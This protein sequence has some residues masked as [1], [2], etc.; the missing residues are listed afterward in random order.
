MLR[1]LTCC[2]I[3]LPFEQCKI[4]DSQ[5]VTFHA[6]AHVTYAVC[7]AAILSDTSS[8][9]DPWRYTRLH[10]L[11]PLPKY[12]VVSPVRPMGVVLGRH[13]EH[14]RY[15]SSAMCLEHCTR[16]GW[17]KRTG[18]HQTEVCNTR[19]LCDIA[20]NNSHPEYNLL[21]HSRH[22]IGAYNRI[23]VDRSSTI[24]FIWRN[25]RSCSHCLR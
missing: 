6:A 22:D 7:P 4:Q 21:R 18:F 20:N 12:R 19:Q 11:V 13:Q 24:D 14:L 10:I 17:D 3:G 23:C 16:C 15:K 9:G 8:F 1:G 2:A 5:V 25:V